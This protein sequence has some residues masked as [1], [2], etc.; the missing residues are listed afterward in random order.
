[1][2]EKKLEVMTHM[3]CG[4]FFS[5]KL[6]NIFIT[7][8]RL[9]FSLITKDDKKE[10]ERRLEEKVKGKSFKERLSIIASHGYVLPDRYKD[11]AMDDLI[12]ENPNNF[13][14]SFEEIISIKI[15]RPKTTDSKGYTKKDYLIIKTKDKKLKVLPV[16]K[17]ELIRLQEIIG[18]KV[19]VPRII[20]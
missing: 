13:Q 20:L 6:C 16:T 18:D 3:N 2:T 11:M 19:K 8:K 5:M 17:D 4:T 7:D 14:F 1:M 9:I 12:D 15:K 10:T